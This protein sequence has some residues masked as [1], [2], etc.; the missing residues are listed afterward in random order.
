MLLDFES[1]TVLTCI[2]VEGRFCATIG[3]Y[4]NCCLP[5]PAT[6]Y[7]YPKDF[8]SWYRA[9]EALNLAG[10]VCM[11]F[12]LV[13]FVCLPAEQTRRHYLS[14]CLIVAAIFLAVSRRP[15]LENKC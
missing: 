8:N 14:Y 13:S 1:S 3:E 15:S 4:G 6:D 2:A 9:A 10:L 12:L 11:L 7:L 5:C